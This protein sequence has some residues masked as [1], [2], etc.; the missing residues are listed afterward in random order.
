MSPY[1][2]VTIVVKAQYSDTMYFYVID[3]SYIPTLIIQ[4]YPWLLAELVPT[5]QKRQAKQW[6]KN[7]IITMILANAY[8]IW[9]LSL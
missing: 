8:I 9:N 7:E 2:T 3:E 1:P 6:A 4:D 5:A